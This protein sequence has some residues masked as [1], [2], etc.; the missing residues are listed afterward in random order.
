MPEAGAEAAAD[1]DPPPVRLHYQPQ[2]QAEPEELHLAQV[3]GLA[4]QV[5]LMEARVLVP[6][7]VQLVP[8]VAVVD[9]VTARRQAQQPQLQVA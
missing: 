3:A 4:V 1:P 7:Q 5:A 9:R 6:P 8:A 2:A